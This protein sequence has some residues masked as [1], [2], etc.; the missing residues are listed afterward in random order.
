MFVF[1]GKS[2]DESPPAAADQSKLVEKQPDVKEAPAAVP[3]H[4]RQTLQPKAVATTEN[5]VVIRFAESLGCLSQ[6]HL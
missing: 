3:N 1:R 4:L 2:N 6:L 5:K